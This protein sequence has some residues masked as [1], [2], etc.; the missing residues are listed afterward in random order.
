LR[1]IL[2]D[3][4]YIVSPKTWMVLKKLVAIVLWQLEF[5]VYSVTGTVQPNFML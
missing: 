5:H 3:R 1:P 2:S 4:S